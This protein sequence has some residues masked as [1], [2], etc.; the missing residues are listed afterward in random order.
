[1]VRPS[2]EPGRFNNKTFTVSLLPEV[3]A[4]EE[5]KMLKEYFPA[6]RIEKAKKR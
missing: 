4:G 2:K 5:P 6:L 3:P 1:M